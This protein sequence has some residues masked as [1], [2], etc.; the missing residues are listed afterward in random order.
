MTPARFAIVALLI[1]TISTAPLCLAKDS[2]SKTTSDSQTTSDSKA[3]PDAKTSTDATSSAPESSPSTTGATTATDTKSSG[4]SSSSSGSLKGGVMSVA[5]TA[6]KE[7]KEIG[8]T[9]HHLSGSINNVFCEVQRQDTV[10]LSSPDVIGTMVIPAVPDASG[11]ISMGTLPPRKKWLDYFNYQVASLID[12]LYKESHAVVLP[13][14]ASSQ[15]G[16]DWAKI[17][18]LVNQMVPVYKK[19]KDLSE[20]PK[21]DNMAI[22]TQAQMLQNTVKEIDKLRKSVYSELKHEDKTRKK[23]TK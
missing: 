4:T 20:G 22:A 14:D 12:I 8:D 3:S 13:E 1:G 11:L 16:S 2:D 6:E 10:M 5:A 18:D 19:M 7:V 21:Y 15:A 17:K 9:C 23:S